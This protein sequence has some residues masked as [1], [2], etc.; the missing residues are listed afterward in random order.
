MME[1]CMERV[2]M[3]LSPFHSGTEVCISQHTLAI[4]RRTNVDGVIW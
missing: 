4:K 1:G 3:H 2:H